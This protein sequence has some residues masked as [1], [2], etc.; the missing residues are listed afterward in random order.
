MLSMWSV[1]TKCAYLIPH[2]CICSDWLITKKANIQSY[3]W[4]TVAK[5][6]MRVNLVCG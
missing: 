5:L 4:A 6:G 2:L 1:V 3:V